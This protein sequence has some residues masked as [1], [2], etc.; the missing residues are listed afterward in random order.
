LLY[1]FN[2]N[3]IEDGSFIYAYNDA[4]QLVEVLKKAE[5][6]R[7][8][9]QFFYDES[10]SRVKKIEDGIVSYYIT[11]DY[12]IEDGEGTVYYFANGGR[13]AKNSDEGMF[14]YLDDHLGSTNVMID[15]DGELVE[16]TLY[17]P[18]GSHREG[19]EEK[20]SFTGKE[21]DSE[22]GL[23]YYGARYYNPETFVFTQADT[24]IPNVYNP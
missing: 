17:Y 14:W 21:F 2:G 10:G 7:V 23:Y 3:L 22:I 4:N 19:G 16:R 20:Y 1:D 13:I 11:E 24:I 18:F 8:I 9:A 15:A 5:N 6:N 12:D